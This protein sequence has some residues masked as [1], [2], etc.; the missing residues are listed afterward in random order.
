[1]SL[2]QPAL[3]AR[4]AAFSPQVLLRP[5]RSQELLVYQHRAIKVLGSA[6]EGVKQLSPPFIK[7]ITSIFKNLGELIFG[8]F[9]H[10][11]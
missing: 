11:M 3:L 6:E 9:H 2:L 4:E 7:N 1:M 10:F 8:S 5:R